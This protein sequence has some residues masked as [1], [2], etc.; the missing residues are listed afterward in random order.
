MRLRRAYLYAALAVVAVV[1]YV[2][3]I[4]AYWLADAVVLAAAAGAV[5]FFPRTERGVDQLLDFLTGVLGFRGSPMRVPPEANRRGTSPW[6]SQLRRE[7]MP[8]S[9]IAH[10]VTVSRIRYTDSLARVS[11]SQ[12]ERALLSQPGWRKLSGES[13]EEIARKASDASVKTAQ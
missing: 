13:L 8:R 1:A 3:W 10:Y 11:E 2:V 6:V 12:F 4:G 9:R 5:V 7:L